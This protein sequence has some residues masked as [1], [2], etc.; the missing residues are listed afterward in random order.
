ME[1]STNTWDDIFKQNGR[2]FNAPHSDMPG[3]VQLM[4]DRGTKT[5]LDLG[6]GTGR[7][8][9]YLAKNG[10]VVY[11]LDS[12]PEAIRATQQWLSEEGLTADLKLGNMMEPLPYQDAFFD[13]LLSIKVIN[14]GDSAAI[15]KIAQ[16]ITRVLK[17]GGLL[18]VAVVTSKNMAKTWKQVEPNT[19]IPLDGAEK[20]LAHHFFSPEE[21][22][23]VFSGF[24]IEDIHFDEG[25]HHCMTGF[26]K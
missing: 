23:E 3:I 13:A 20:G 6:N 12:S 5:V 15:R 25:M 22:R 7:H 18:F 26:K 10:F 16:E 21:L 4:K 11:G 17:Q 1:I 24:D 14:H 2:V 9:V 19:F 8:A